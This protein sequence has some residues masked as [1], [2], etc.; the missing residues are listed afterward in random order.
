MAKDIQ[1]TDASTGSPTGFS[2]DFGDDTPVSTAENPL[3]TYV[4][5]DTYNVTETITKVGYDPDSVTKQV[6]TEELP[7]DWITRATY[8]GGETNI[9][10]M[11]F[12]KIG[13]LGPYAMGIMPIVEGG[14]SKLLRWN[15]ID[16]WTVVLDTAG[17]NSENV[18]GMVVHNGR[19]YCYGPA[20]GKLFSWGTGETEWT[21]VL[22]IAFDPAPA[23]VKM[24]DFEGVLYI[25][26]NYVDGSWTV[27][28]YDAAFATV[29]VLTENQAGDTGVDI[30]GHVPG[31][32]LLV[33]TNK[34][35][36][37][38]VNITTGDITDMI[39]TGSLTNFCKFI[40]YS[41][42]RYY[43]VCRSSGKLLS[44]GIGET[45][46]TEVETVTGHSIEAYNGRMYIIG[47]HAVVTSRYKVSSE[48]LVTFANPVSTTT[49]LDTTAF[50]NGRLWATAGPYLKTIDIDV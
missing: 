27:F 28:Y 49:Y 37:C 3:H 42:G 47:D 6:S 41:D 18:N 11:V 38:S 40:T 7:V 46:W 26:A 5:D 14:H 48:V 44:W 36:L 31:T 9:K 43:T 35:R 23:S 19:I 1:F 4:E 16:A 30:Q 10:G 22:E 2:W 8:P 13:D 17:P 24:V 25:L 20:S 39:A 34:G 32:D 33:L 45:A 15:G 50:I 29:E 12:Y 21:D